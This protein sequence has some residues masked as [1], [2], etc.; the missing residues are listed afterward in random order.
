MNKISAK[1][2]IIFIFGVTYISLKTYPSLFISQGGRDTWIYALIIYLIFIAFVMYII[3]V[4]ESKNIYN[5]NEIFTFGL[6]K[7]IGNIFLFLFSLGLFLSSLECASV[8]A[9]VIKS[10]FFLETPTWYIVLFFILPSVFLIG[11]ELRTL[12]TF[13]IILISSLGINTAILAIITEKYKNIKYVL[14]LLSGNVAN[15]LPSTFLLIL[16]S[17]SAFVI[18]LPY[19]RYL[20]NG[21]NLKKHTMIGLSLLG[22]IFIY[23]LIGVLSSF[24]PI[25]AANLFYPEFTQSQRVQIGGVLEFGDF[26]FLYQTVVG[27]F[28]K[29]VLS[30]YGV[31][32][33]YKKYIKN[34]TYFITIYT[35]AIFIFSTFISRNNYVLFI[36][37]KYY[38][39]VNLILFIIIPLI[40]FIFFQ[41]RYKNK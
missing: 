30:S 39:Y 31:Y 17:L 32:I 33:I 8:E 25:R 24:G 28:L 40:T 35:L 18:A 14:P 27:Y 23:I 16:G 5:I 13:S 29:Y 38:Q 7:F 12:L 41:I 26:F 2:F 34:D 9:N 6:S 37:L 4:M 19:L 1:H 36:I 20:N 10:C 3:S 15:E 22:I 11:K 21:K